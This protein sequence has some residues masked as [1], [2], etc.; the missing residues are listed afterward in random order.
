MVKFSDQVYQQK[1]QKIRREL[2]RFLSRTDDKLFLQFM[3]SINTLQTEFRGNVKRYLSFPRSAYGAPLGSDYA[4]P[5]WEIETLLTLLF[6]TDKRPKIHINYDNFETIVPVINNLR[7]LENHENRLTCTEDKIFYELHRIGQRQFGWQRGFHSSERLY[8]YVFIY[9]KG[10]C[11]TNFENKYGFTIEQFL[12]VSCVLYTQLSNSP[13]IKPIEI[14]VLDVTQELIDK[15][16]SLISLPLSDLRVD[17]QTLIKKTIEGGRIPTAYLPGSLRK[18]PIIRS[19]QD[20]NILISPLS[21]LIMYRATVG[22]YYDMINSAPSKK[23]ADQ[24]ITEAN[25]RFEQYVGM[26]IE[27]FCPRFKAFPSEQYGPRKARIDTP[28]VLLIDNEEVT[29]VFECKATKLTF[30]AQF[31][32]HPFETSDKAYAQIVKAV[33]QLWRFFSH[34]RI[35]KYTERKISDTA[36][37]V[38]LTIDSWMQMSH[39]L[40]ARV[41]AQAKK[42]LEDDPNVLDVDMRPIIFCSIQDLVDVMYISDEDNLLKTFAN[43]ALPKYAGWRIVEIRRDFGIDVQKKFPLNVEEVLP[44]W[45]VINSSR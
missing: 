31:S 36:N 12:K 26:V 29:T 2:N 45:N 40:Q 33:T 17:A 34:V 8:R 27:K 25:D 3:W 15:T 16:L 10:S 13:W 43:A 41:F 28:D 32:E 44:W 23:E 18:F 7:K 5:K 21:Q 14:P 35:G 6:T 30:E 42:A 24:A 1:L 20:Q 22:L 9:G 37:A 19:P 38:V 11:A 39:A 4:L